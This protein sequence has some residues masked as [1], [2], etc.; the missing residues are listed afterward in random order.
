MSTPAVHPRTAALDGLRGVAVLT[1]L[2]HHVRSIFFGSTNATVLPGAFLGVD[3]FFVLSGFLITGL[4]LQEHRRHHSIRLAGFYRRRVLRL[5]PALLVVLVAHALY[6]WR[7]GV[8]ASIE[9]PTLQSILLYYSNWRETILIPEGVGHMW[10]LAVEEQFYLVW[11]LLLLGLLW[12][13]RSRRRLLAPTVLVM[14]VVVM[15]YRVW[16]W[17]DGM[18]P[19]WIYQRTDTRLDSLLV[20]ALLAVA[21][22]GIEP[23]AGF[24]ARHR[25]VSVGAW[26]GLAVFLGSV[27]FA[28]VDG[29]FLYLGGFTLVAAACAAIVL[30]VLPGSP[31]AGA[32]PLRFRPLCVVGIVSYGLY[33]WHLP[34]FVAVQRYGDQV[35]PIPRVGIA[36]ALT[37]LLTAGSWRFVEQPFLRWKDRLEGRAVTPR[38]EIEAARAS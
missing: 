22:S 2:V 17:H 8:P 7:S 38:P 19:L 25:W 36:L 32:R 37:V 30:A 24:Y 20:G 3:L 12:L 31:W 33:L 1:V 29:A 9:R 21:L 35:P 15:I 34:V 26:L 23:S 10:S 6:A 11:P 13:T 4:L 18:F 14:V 27:L 28:Q 5:Y 16:R